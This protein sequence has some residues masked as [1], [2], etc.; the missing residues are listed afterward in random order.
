MSRKYILNHYSSLIDIHKDGYQP[1]LDS[2]WK[3]FLWDEDIKG[4][5]LRQDIYSDRDG[6]VDVEKTV[7]L[8][9]A[10]I[11]DED[12]QELKEA[13]Y[14]YSDWEYTKGKVSSTIK[15]DESVYQ[16]ILG[17]Y[18]EAYQKSI[19][20]IESK[21]IQKIDIDYSMPIGQWEDTLTVTIPIDFN[22]LEPDTLYRIGIY[23]CDGNPT[24]CY[25]W[26]WFEFFQ[27]PK[28]IEDIFVPHSAYLK[29]RKPIRGMLYFDKSTNYRHYKDFFSDIHF[30]KVCEE[31]EVNPT[32]V[33][34][35]LNMKYD[36]EKVPIFNIIMSSGNTII[37]RDFCRL[38]AIEGTRIVAYCPLSVENLHVKDYNEIT[39]SLQVFDHTIA[40]FSFSTNKTEQGVFNL[41]R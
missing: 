16:K 29:V 21:I 20:E 39:A 28:P 5:I 14:R 12:C 30:D 40:C 38:V 6:G 7:K 31:V 24:S 8:R 17:E 27:F 10:I 41:Q 2:K 32:L 25:E 13:E 22:I 34:F 3:S 1:I 35:E 4:I 18:S 19:A 9:L 11:K 36:K 37:H 33:C 15:V 26:S 23:D